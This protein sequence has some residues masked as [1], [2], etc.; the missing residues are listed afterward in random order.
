V[1]ET[2]PSERDCQSIQRTLESFFGHRMLGPFLCM[3]RRCRRF[4]PFSCEGAPPPIRNIDTGGACAPACLA[5]LLKPVCRGSLRAC[6][7]ASPV[8]Q[9]NVDITTTVLT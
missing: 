3:R 5:S 2:E 8:S 1:H 7:H 6:L 4:A 9:H